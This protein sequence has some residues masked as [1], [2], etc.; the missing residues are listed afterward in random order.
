MTIKKRYYAEMKDILAIRFT[1]KKC[2]TAI[3][4]KPAL[5]PY[6]DAFYRC[7]NCGDNWF[8]LDGQDVK[9]TTAFISGLANISKRASELRCLMHYEFEQQD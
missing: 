2:H 9:A 4:I 7:H 6:E 1:C 5:E 8:P 3:S